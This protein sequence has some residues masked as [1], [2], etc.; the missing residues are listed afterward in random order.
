[1]QRLQAFK[2]QLMPNGAQQRDMRRFAGSCRFVYNKTLALQQSHHEAGGKFIGYVALAKHLTDWRHSSETPWLKEAPC[3]PLQHALKDLD[4]AYQNF[5]AKRADFPRFKRKGRGE[6]LRYPDPK[7][8][9][10][11]QANSR[12]KLPKLGWMRYRKSRDIAGVARNI[13]LSESG[14]KWYASIQTKQELPQPV[15]AATTA[16]GIDV[17]IARFA[18]L[19]DGRCI[20]PLNSFKQHQLRLARYQRRMARKIKFSKNWKKAKV[21]V[22]KIH[23]AIANARKDFLHKTST[24]ISQ[25]HALV[26][27]EGLQ[28][29]NM[30]RSAK[31]S[32][33]QPGKRVRQKAGLNRCILDQGWA[34][35]RRQLAY[36]MDWSG[37][38]LLA[39]PAHHT[40][41]TCPSCGHVA[42][43]NRRT[44][45]QFQ[46]VACRHTAHA[47]VV[48]A[49]NVLER[50][51]RLLACG[52]GGSGRGR[53][54]RAK[55]AS[56]K[57]E[58]AEA[59]TQET[60]HA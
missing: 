27:I 49:I 26:C 54:I 45:Q 24:T 59:T 43:E 39:V 57:Q 30:S 56:V 55:P 42:A 29:R 17:G 6:S 18:T 19:S 32:R 46:C 13:T 15:P 40:S 9:E 38:L 22:Q 60:A 47:D 1:M 44:Q 2:F 12:I 16:I 37:G 51:Q 14:G 53:K 41:Q 4:R 50:G 25:N 8:F 10:I 21:N 52:E 36:K 5:F 28:V 7:Q 31:G 23:T 20:A 34:E 35:F 3:H 58:P 11:D 33:E 48:G